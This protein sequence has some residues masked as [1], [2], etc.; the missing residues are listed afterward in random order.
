MSDKGKGV[1]RNG[2]VPLQLFLM[3]LQVN[4]EPKEI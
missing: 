1:K 3:V 4:Q 2:G